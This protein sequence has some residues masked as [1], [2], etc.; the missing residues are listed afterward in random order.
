[1]II[2]MNRKLMVLVGVLVMVLNQVSAQTPKKKKEK[3]SFI[4]PGDIIKNGIHRVIYL[5]ISLHWV[6]IM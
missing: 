3:E 1:M 6:I 5:W 4:S 2:D